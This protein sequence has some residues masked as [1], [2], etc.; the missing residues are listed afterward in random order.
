MLLLEAI[1]LKM[2]FF[3]KKLMVLSSI[4]VLGLIGGNCSKSDPQ[5][6]REQLLVS[7]KGWKQ[8]AQTI[9]PAR[10]INGTSVTDYYAQVLQACR[11]DDILYFT[12]PAGQISGPYSIAEAA[13][14]SAVK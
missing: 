14:I 6:P 11:K 12:A 10:S 1:N 9:S 8:I 3:M 5:P 13:T 7:T 4:V 2:K